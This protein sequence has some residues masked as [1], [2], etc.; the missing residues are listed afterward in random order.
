LGE[1]SIFPLWF[2][3]GLVLVLAL[4]ITTAIMAGIGIAAYR[5][6]RSRPLK[7][8]KWAAIIV[9][10]FWLTGLGLGSWLLIAT[11]RQQVEETQR[12][13]TLDKAA[14]I[15][16]VLLPAGTR[17]QLDD[18]RALKVA[19]LPEG[20]MMTLRNATWQGKIE[21]AEPAHTP[22]AAYGQIT[23]GTLAASAVI[24]GISCRAGERVTFFWG[25]HLM[26]CMLSRDFDIPATL[27]APDRSA[28]TYRFRCLADDT[29]ALD[30]VRTGELG[31]CR[32][33]GVADFGEVACA[34]GERI[35][36]SSGY[37]AACTLASSA[38]FGPLKL[39]AG[40]S[41]TYYD[42]RPSNFRLPAQGGPVDGFGLS[43]PAGTEGSFCCHSDAPERLMVSR[44][45]YVTIDGVKLTGFID[46]R[47]GV[48]HSGLLFEHTLIEGKWR[49]RGELVLRDEIVPKQGG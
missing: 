10:P 36:I 40:S 4:P 47:C 7:G 34:A 19:E 20:A 41:V 48:F 18:H 8:L 32:L 45:A 25:G 29:I 24:D 46:F 5:R 13:F 3:A 21:F 42:G 31:G 2:M 17:V 16:G 38:R 28:R 30:G 11:I 9:A 22:N 1:I 33:A 14:E 27:A 15:N 12:Y 49:E 26:G 35:L 23:D 43:L 44:T 39:P 6:D 37:V